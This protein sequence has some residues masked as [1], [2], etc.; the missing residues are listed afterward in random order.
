MNPRFLPARRRLIAAGLSAFASATATA[1]AASPAPGASASSSGATPATGARAD[2][3]A[4]ARAASA[5]RHAPAAHVV[6]VGGGFAGGA[7]ARWLKRLAPALDIT[8]VEPRASFVTGPMSNALLAGIARPAAVT[9]G[10]AALAAEGIR[11]VAQAA[12][13]IDPAALAVTL[14]DGRV[15]RADRLVVAPG[16]APR[17]GGIDGLDETTTDLMPHGWLGGAQFELLRRRFADLRD[18]ATVV[19]GA[20]QN[21]YRCP[22]GPYERASLMAW[23]LARRMRQFRIVIADAKD[24]FTK[25]RLFQLAWDERHPGHIEWIARAAGGEVTG[26][27]ARAGEVRLANGER[28]RADLACIVPPQRAAAIAAAADLTDASGWCP[29]DPADFRSQRHAGV[30]VLGD[31]AIAQPMPKSA[32]SAVSQARLCAAAIA[33]ELAGAPAPEPRLVNTCYSLVAPDAAIS[34]SAVYGV[35]NR[36]VNVVSEGQSELAAGA[37]VRA[38][39]AQAAWAVYA[40]LVGASF[41]G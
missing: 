41:G 31:A 8:L 14:A 32:F 37:D 7:C 22:P 39:E 21:P 6:I 34:V 23:A 2:R 4:P 24:D 9:H 19:I 5:L 18:G 40:G 10:P 28:L 3:I 13:A 16:I 17:F 35:A 26:V 27:D 29:V 15:L 12:T 38:A 33:A 36:Q 25:R 20:P 1:E 30:H 11:V